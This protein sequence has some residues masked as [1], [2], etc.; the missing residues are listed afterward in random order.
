[1]DF[2][3]MDP[4]SPPSR[5]HLPHTKHVLSPCLPKP[6]CHH[7]Q[8]AQP[9]QNSIG[10]PLLLP[11]AEEET[12]HGT[13]VGSFATLDGGTGHGGSAP[14]GCAPSLL[15]AQWQTG[16]H[17]RR[18]PLGNSLL[19]ITATLLPRSPSHHGGLLPLRP[20]GRHHPKEPPGGQ[21]QRTALHHRTLRRL[22][23]PPCRILCHL[24]RRQ[25]NRP[26]RI[27]LR[28]E[29]LHPHT[30]PHQ[31]RRGHPRGTRHQIRRHGTKGIRV[32]LWYFDIGNIPKF[33]RRG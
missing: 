10:R 7:L 14:D 9:D 31:Q 3:I 8:C 4:S 33:V 23:P 18:R 12:I 6:R 1:M 16:H 27:L 32:D 2:P 28:M 19:P 17:Q 25:T 22:P 11:F 13:N 26:T 21:S 24:R 15:L 30:H 20:R 29:R 5:N